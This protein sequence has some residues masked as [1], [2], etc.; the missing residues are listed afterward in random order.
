MKTKGN[1]TLSDFTDGFARFDTLADPKRQHLRPLAWALSYPDILKHKIKIRKINMEGLKPPYILLCNHNSFLDFKV[2]TAAVFPNR[3]NNVVAIDGFITPNGKGFSSREWLLRLVGCICKRKFTNDITI[4][5]HL[6]KV[7]LR[8]DIAVIYPEARYSLCGTNAILPGSLGKLCKLLKVPVVTLITHGHHVNSPFW[9]THNNNLKNL[10]SDMTQIL[11]AA[12]LSELPI[13]RINAKIEA[14]FEYDD[15]AWQL[16]NGIKN[17]YEKRAE[18]LEKVLYQCPACMTEYKMTSSGT[19][20]MCENCAKIWTLSE[21]GTISADEGKTE[22]SH[23]PDWYEWER[24]NVRAQIESGKYYFESPVSVMSLPNSKGFIDLGKGK[25][26]HDGG[27]FHVN[28]SGEYGNF[29]MEKPVSSLYSCHIEYN[30]LGKYGD[31]IDLNTLT[32]T[33]YIYPKCDLFS[34]TKIS[35]ATEEF[36]KIFAEGKA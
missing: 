10:S 14:A 21:L 2:A 31:C 28:V 4:V 8:G 29:E 24:S 12:E 13:D 3:A 26:V 11:T 27:G 16:E 23:I 9:N 1:N 22:F 35:L 5:R 20:I 25:L 15:F 30:Y 34:V 18:G 32:D 6:K 33:W 19:Q 17:T 36:Y 7:I